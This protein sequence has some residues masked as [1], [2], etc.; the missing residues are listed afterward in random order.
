MPIFMYE[1]KYGNQVEK[2]VHKSDEQ[3]NGFRRMQVPQRFSSG[4]TRD[5]SPKAMQKDRMRKSLSHLED[6]GEIRK[7]RYTK[8]Q[9]KKIWEV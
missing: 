8:N 9:L 2:F 5:L 7:S 4:S 1:D 6:N 3:I